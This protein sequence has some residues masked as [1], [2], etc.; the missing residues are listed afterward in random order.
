MTWP[1]GHLLLVPYCSTLPGCLTLQAL[2]SA[3][4]HLPYPVWYLPAPSAAVTVT[5]EFTL[6]DLQMAFMPT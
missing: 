4:L 1:R 5:A 2:P 3:P 6:L